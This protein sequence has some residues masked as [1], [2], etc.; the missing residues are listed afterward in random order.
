ML[1]RAHKLTRNFPKANDKAL[2]L[3]ISHLTLFFSLFHRFGL[4][5]CANISKAVQTHENELKLFYLLLA[6]VVLCV[7][8]CVVTALRTI[9]EIHCVFQ[10]QTHL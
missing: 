4:W 9:F 5:I 8:V 6:L 7:C 1:E 2:F 3:L 10:K